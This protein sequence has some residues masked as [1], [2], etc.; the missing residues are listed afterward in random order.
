MGDA[1]ETLGKRLQ[2]L[3]VAAGFSQPRLAAAAGVP[4]GTLRNLE[5]D[6]RVPL[7]DTARD[8]ARA[9]GLSLE[10]LIDDAVIV[11]PQQ[12][13]DRG[14]PGPVGRPRKAPPVEPPPPKEGPKGERRKA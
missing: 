8:V 1:R 6:R 13:R 14:P 10:E 2:R 9:L 3:R 5:Y 7:V 12:R 11:T 4:L